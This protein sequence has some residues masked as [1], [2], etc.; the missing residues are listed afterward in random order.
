MTSARVGRVRRVAILLLLA[1]LM[2]LIGCWRHDAAITQAPVSIAL[3]TS[4]TVV[5]G[6]QTVT[7]TASVYDPSNQGATWTLS[8]LNFG[9]LSQSTATS[10]TYTAPVGFTTPSTVDH[11]S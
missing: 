9:A 5:T 11:E 1:G 10:V 7:V 8:P 2:L 3:T 4:S 6:G